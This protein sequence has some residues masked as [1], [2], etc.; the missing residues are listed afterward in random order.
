LLD[1]ALELGADAVINIEKENLIDRANELTGGAGFDVGVGGDEF[2]LEG[3]VVDDGGLGRGGRLG[4][5]RKCGGA[6]KK[7]RDA[8]GAEC[9]DGG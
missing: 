3:G 1:L 8:E 6:E 7:E 9:H 2:D 5:E 4:G